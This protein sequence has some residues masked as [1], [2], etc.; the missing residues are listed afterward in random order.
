MA[1]GEEPSLCTDSSKL[2][3]WCQLSSL[4]EQVDIE[5]A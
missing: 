4:L 1:G 2:I 5:M 3:D